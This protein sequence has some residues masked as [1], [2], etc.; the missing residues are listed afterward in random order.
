MASKTS[1][2]TQ[3]SARKEVITE[4]DNMVSRFQKLANIKI[5]Q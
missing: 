1:G 2:T 4:S 3:S 5:N